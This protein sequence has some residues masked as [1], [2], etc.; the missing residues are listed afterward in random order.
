MPRLDI[1]LV[2]RHH[3]E[4]NQPVIDGVSR[5]KLLTDIASLTL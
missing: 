2:Q 1:I 4:V 5:Y 3:D